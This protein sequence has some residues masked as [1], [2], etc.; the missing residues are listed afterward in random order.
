MILGGGLAGLAAAACLAE[1][2]FEVELIEKRPVLGGRASSFI[3]PGETERI[4]NCQHVLL[5]CCTNLLDFFFRFD[6]V[7]CFRFYNSFRFLGPRGFSSMSASVLPAPIHLLPALLRFRD[8]DWPDRFAIGRAMRTILRFPERPPDEPMLQWLKSQRQTT[9]AIENFWRVVLTSALNEDLETLSSRDAFKVFFDA[10]LKNRQGYRMG[11]PAIPLSELYSTELIDERCTVHTGTAASALQYSEGC[12]SGLTLRDGTTRTAD[13]YI[14][15]VTPDAFYSLLPED[16]RKQWPETK[17]LEK[18][19]W[20][21]ITGIHLWFDKPVTV[22]DH[23]AIVGRPIQWVFNRTAIDSPRKRNSAPQYIQLV[24]SASRSLMTMR[25]GE[26]L[27]LALKELGELFPAAKSAKL[28]KSVIVK[29]AKAT[30]S[31]RPG[32]EALRFPQSTPFHNLYLAGDWTDTGWP[33]TME[34]AVRSG[35]RAAELV[36]EAAGAPQNFLQP[37]LP[38]APLVRLLRLI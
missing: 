22:L 17:N 15:A 4:D 16:L 38:V 7:E 32:L 1:A 26:G 19:E 8:L 21:P 13:F 6:S 3:P 10:F 30:L 18:L 11:V 2:G 20:S 37:E 35:Y 9:R 14:S 24:V 12:I 36:T 33:F 31:P 5:G 23:V 29:E 27:D 28:L 34:G 25:R